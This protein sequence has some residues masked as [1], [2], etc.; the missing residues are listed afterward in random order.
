MSRAKLYTETMVVTYC[1][2]VCNN[3]VW[4]FQENTV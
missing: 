1:N 3:W 2:Q 4:Y